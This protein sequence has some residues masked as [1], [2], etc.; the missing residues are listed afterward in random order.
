MERSKI[1]KDVESNTSVSQPQSNSPDEFEPGNTVIYALHGKCQL[2]SIET[3]FANGESIRFYKLEIQKPNASRSSKKEPAIW[4]PVSSA[5]KQGMRSPISTDGTE[6]VFEIL[7][8]REYYFELGQPWH[9]IHSKL[10]ESIR[11]EGAIG[12]AKV[13]SYLYVLKRKQLVPP[14]EAVKMQENVN[15]LLLRE[16][17]EATGENPRQ[18]EEKIVKLFRH[19]L[20][21]DH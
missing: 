17:S 18:L 13:A 21:P 1:K 16:L 20:L 2:V 3:R 11:A 19:K 12:L 10:E 15:K 7:S 8:S 4:I 5:K 9:A 6:R 14:S